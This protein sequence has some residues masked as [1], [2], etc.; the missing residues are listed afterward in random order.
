[1]FRNI[2]P[3][4]NI[5]T[6]RHLVRLRIEEHAHMMLGLVG[7]VFGIGRKFL[8]EKFTAIVYFSGII[9][10]SR[11]PLMRR[12]NTLMDR[13]RVI[14]HCRRESIT[15]GLTGGTRINFAAGP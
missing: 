12:L 3:K 4:H 9:N 15:P 2:G 1:M 7:C 11:P 6:D 8:D 14:T 10:Y 13:T 5:L